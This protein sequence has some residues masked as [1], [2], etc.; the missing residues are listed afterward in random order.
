MQWLAIVFV[1]IILS[2]VP[3]RAKPALELEG[4]LAINSFA[5]ALRISAIEKVSLVV[6]E[7]YALSV[8]GEHSARNYSFTNALAGGVEYRL[9][10]GKVQLPAGV[11]G[12]INSLHIGQYAFV[13]PLAGGHCG[14][15]LWLTEA[16]SVRCNYYGKLYFGE[17]TIF[18]SD[19]FLGVNVRI[20][21]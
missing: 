14:V 21:P 7:R 5:N 9:L 1:V 3:G 15:I 8:F 20:K 17:Q 10:K 18:G 19:L 4:C 2:W 11:F 16:A 12:G 6:A 13:Q